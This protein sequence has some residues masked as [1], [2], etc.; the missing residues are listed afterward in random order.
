MIQTGG[1]EKTSSGTVLRIKGQFDGNETVY[2]LILEEMQNKIFTV[3]SSVS[4]EIVLTQPGDRISVRYYEA[5][6]QPVLSAL[7]FDN[8]MFSQ[9]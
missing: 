6:G 8:L 4:D 5:E 7:E 1:E 9:S 2:F 3:T